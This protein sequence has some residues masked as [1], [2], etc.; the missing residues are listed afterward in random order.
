MTSIIR[1]PF[2][3]AV[4]SLACR[5]IGLD[6][7]LR[8]GSSLSTLPGAPKDSCPMNQDHLCP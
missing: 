2:R 3:L 7:D 4:H 1:G 5:S 8:V 6:S